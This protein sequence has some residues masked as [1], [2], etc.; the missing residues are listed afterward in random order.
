MCGAGLISGHLT[1]C[2]GALEPASP[3]LPGSGVV[4]GLGKQGLPA[5]AVRDCDRDPLAEGPP[6]WGE[7]LAVASVD[8]LACP[9]RKLGFVL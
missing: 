1:D 3:G 7:R 6:C 2:L 5:A 8:Q 9:D 4:A